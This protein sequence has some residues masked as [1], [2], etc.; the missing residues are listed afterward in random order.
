MYETF[1]RVET[2][3]YRGFLFP[4]D[5]RNHVATQ[6]LAVLEIYYQLTGEQI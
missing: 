3:L 2:D 5:I 4:A 1:Q 6:R